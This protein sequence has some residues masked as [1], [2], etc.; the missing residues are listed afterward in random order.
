M[1][2]A[3]GW[4]YSAFFVVQEGTWSSMRGVGDVLESKGIFTSFYDRGSHYWST[5]RA[6]GRVKG[7]SDAVREGDEGAI[8]M[9][10]G[11][12]PEAR[13]RSERMF[14]TLQGRL[15]AEYCIIR[16]DRMNLES[17]IADSP[18]WGS[19]SLRKGEDGCA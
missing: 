12:S 15:P 7:E 9:I 14:K 16:H 13:G 18:G 3:T 1:D 10:P 5:P 19:C 2:D 8:V 6:G 11:Y 17:C 4:I